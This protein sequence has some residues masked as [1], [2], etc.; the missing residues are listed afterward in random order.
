MIDNK[1]SA[2]NE[3]VLDY[4]YFT[5]LHEKQLQGQVLAF[6]CS[7]NVCKFGQSTWKPYL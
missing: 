7:V 1:E 6:F 2:Y 4:Y 3:L 5:Y